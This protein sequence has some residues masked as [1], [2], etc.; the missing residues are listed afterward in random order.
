MNEKKI[1]EIMKKYSCTREEAE[2]MIAWD[3]KTE[4]MSDKE[5][6]AE[7]TPEQIAAQKKMTITTSGERKERKAPE[8]KPNEAK[9]AIITA[10]A[11]GLSFFEPT[12]TNI[13]RQI[14][15]QLDGVDYSVTLTA[16]RKKK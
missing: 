7:L 2:E 14:D 9:R 3:A 16:H 15:F 12:V 13:E 10:I 11:E 6:K 8:R 1:A 5:I 4:K